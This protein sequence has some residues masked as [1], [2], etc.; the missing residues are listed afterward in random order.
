MYKKF[1]GTGVAIV[2]PFNED[3][4]IDYPAL[5]NLIEHL[6]KAKIEY[7]VLMGTTGE[8][9]TLNKNEKIELLNFTKEKINQRVP[10]VLGIGGNNTNDVKNN[11]KSTDFFSIDAILSVSPYYNKPSQKG[12]YEHYKI[13][14]ET[15]P[16]P[17]ILYNVP[18]RTGK[19]IAAETTLK[20]SYDFKNIIAIK[21]AS[22]DFSQIMEI[23]KNKPDDFIVISG[24]DLLTLPLIAIGAK[25]VISVV[26]NAFPFEF[27]EMV[28]KA[29]NNN[30]NE[31]KKIHYKFYNLIN[32]LF[33]E[34]NPGGIKAALNSLGIIKNELRLPLTSVSKELEEKISQA[35]KELSVTV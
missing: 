12:I 26:A 35:C 3:K 9:V 18:S 23:I 2:T 20:L 11:I 1:Y 28:R 8:S 6:I 10:L 34:N 25:G 19:N 17:I 5:A 13:I 27:S 15:S 31:A 33:A 32:L 21:E 14:A 29:L 16:V 7:I 24:D 30:F 22:G 4:S